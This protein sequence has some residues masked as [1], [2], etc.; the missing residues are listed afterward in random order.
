MDYSGTYYLFDFNDDHAQRRVSDVRYNALA[1]LVPDN[2]A[3]WATYTTN[4]RFRTSSLAG[5]KQD[6]SVHI[7]VRS[8]EKLR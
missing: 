1:M 4:S 5:Y 7:I 6:T 2:V 8:I 3:R